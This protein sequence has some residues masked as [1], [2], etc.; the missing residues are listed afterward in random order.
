MTRSSS[1]ARA[2]L[3]LLLASAL[4]AGCAAAPLGQPIVGYTCCNLRAQGGWVSSNNVQG[5]DL[6][7]AGTPV[8]LTSI[9]RK[10]YLYGLA[11]TQE[12]AFRDDAAQSE[13]QTLRWI[14]Q[15]VV[16]QDPQPLLASWPKEVQTAVATVRVFPGMTR[17]Q[18]A[19]AIG[20]PS[21]T[22]TPDLAA[23]TW[24][25]WTPAEDQ[26]VDLRFGEDGRLADIT[27]K[28]SA[29]RTVALPR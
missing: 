25:Y 16:P 21:P 23:S 18:V 26:P 27:G 12:I 2:G 15:V 13:A 17:E 3:P 8:R 29:V 9:K 4:L 11:G 22:D 28:P 19:M 20:H 5:G 10:Y 24:R 7:P 1:P 6:I 14:R